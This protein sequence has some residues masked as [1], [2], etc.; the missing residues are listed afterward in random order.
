MLLQS[1]SAAS[2]SLA[3]KPMVAEL[4]E[5]RLLDFWRAIKSETL[6]ESFS[7]EKSE[8]PEAL[9]DR[10]SRHSL[11]DRARHSKLSCGG[12]MARLRQMP[13]R[14]LPPL[15]CYSESLREQAARRAEDRLCPFIRLRIS[16]TAPG[17]SPNASTRLWRVAP[18]S[19]NVF[20]LPARSNRKDVSKLLHV[21]RC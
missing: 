2:Q 4:L 17:S 8:V 14:T 5:E 7:D 6:A 13:D 16:T 12:G 3:S 11:G 9:Q 20:T 19:R 21:N 18:A 15:R 1:L 10:Q